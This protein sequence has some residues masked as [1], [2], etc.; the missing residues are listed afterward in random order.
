MVLI[1]VAETTYRFRVMALY[2]DD[3]S[4][5]SPARKFTLPAPTGPQ[6][7]ATAPFIVDVKPLSQHSIALH[8]QV[9]TLLPVCAAY[10]ASLHTHTQPF[11]GL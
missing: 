8:W 11:N 9:G 2:S 5:Q 7:P 1:A 6:L 4:R 10:L 3:V